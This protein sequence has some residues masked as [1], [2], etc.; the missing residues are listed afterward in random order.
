MSSGWNTTSILYASKFH[1]L[2]IKKLK[3]FTL[4]SLNT[5]P[6]LYVTPF[7]LVEKVNKSIS[8]IFHHTRN[9]II[10]HYSTNFMHLSPVLFIT[11]LFLSTYAVMS[12]KILPPFIWTFILFFWVLSEYCAHIFNNKPTL[13]TDFSIFPERKIKDKILV[14]LNYFI[15]SQD[16]LNQK[17]ISLT[18]NDQNF[19]I[20]M[21]YIMLCGIT[22]P[23][24]QD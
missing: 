23:Y 11:P 10:F 2:M 14:N 6:P 20:L 15:W 1:Q 4:D 16:H 21:F 19:N 18:Q 22:R 7:S 24:H 13:L 9:N 12:Y 5:G 8:I 3:I 17:K